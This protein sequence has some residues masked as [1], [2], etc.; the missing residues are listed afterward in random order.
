MLRQRAQ[1]RSVLVRSMQ[2]SETPVRLYCRIEAPIWRRAL[3]LRSPKGSPCKASRQAGQMTVSQHKHSGELALDVRAR[4]APR[5]RLRP[6]VG[7]SNG[8]PR[9]PCWESTSARSRLTECSGDP[10]RRRARADRPSLQIESI[11]V[12]EPPVWI[13]VRSEFP[14]VG[15]LLPK[16]NGMEVAFLVRC[17]SKPAGRLPTGWLRDQAVLP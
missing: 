5:L 17:L 11:R 10:R 3:P 14:N 15:Y 9:M 1:P 6:F 7:R 4:T 16:E 2:D 8:W 13:C 12:D